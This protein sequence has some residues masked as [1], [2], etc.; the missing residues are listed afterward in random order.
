[1]NNIDRT[2]RERSEPDGG[3][4]AVDWVARAKA[5]CPMIAAASDR[6]ERDRELP[7]EIISALHEAELFRMLLPRSIGG[8]EADPL[9]WMEVLEAV[10]AA[11][12]STAW[13]LGQ[14]Q[15]CTSAAAFLDAAAAQEIFGK[16]DSVL[17]WGPGNR[18][19]KAVAAEGGYRVSGEFMFASGSRHADWLGAHCAVMEP[20]G[21]PR[22]DEA[23]KPVDRTMLFPK[24]SAEMIDV[25][26][27]IGL[28]GTGSDNYAVDDLF[29]PEAHTFRRN[30]RA[31]LRE[32]GPLYRIPL[33][34]LYGMA[35]A[36]VA[37]GIARAMLDEFIDLA[38]NKV[39][40]RTAGVL[41]ENA[42]IQSEVAQ[43]KGRLGSSRAFLVEMIGQ[44]WET[45]CSGEEFPLEQRAR[46]RVSIT[47]AM[48]QAS[49]VAD[50]AYQAS[51]TTGIFETNSF[52]R[53]FRDMHT[54]S[55]QGQAHRSN[56]EAAGQV[57]LGL[58]PTSPR[59]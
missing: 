11:D 44:T 50:F 9:A 36:G 20:D 1:M 40:S 53:R 30:A 46:L 28:K 21:S 33:L 10:S 7:P 23:G 38:A 18:T 52:E 31:D 8:G 43:A 26:Q 59:V 4:G 47:W 35:F 3:A 49:E 34:T 45:A 24:S 48:N 55:Q 6:I 56:F 37:I 42:V 32:T 57:L 51:G 2:A 15:G 27:V 41:R 54:V 19:A 17:A 25:W 13:C 58:Q 39:A 12:A 22:M 16:P 14:G 5:L 29:V